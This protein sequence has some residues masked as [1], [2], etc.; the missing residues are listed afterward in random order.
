MLNMKKFF[1]TTY[2]DCLFS[3]YPNFQSTVAESFEWKIK[4]GPN[5]FFMFGIQNNW[6]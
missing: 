4:A 5:I 3:W 6:F 2:Q 1:E